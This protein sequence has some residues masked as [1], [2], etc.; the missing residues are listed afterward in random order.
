MQS[1]HIKFI[2]SPAFLQ[3]KQSL[4]GNIVPQNQQFALGW[5]AFT[6]VKQITQEQFV[7]NISE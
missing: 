7:F 6:H 4:L 5:K 1:P 2:N 3:I